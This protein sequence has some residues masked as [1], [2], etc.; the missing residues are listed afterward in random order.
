MYHFVSADM[1][2]YM[3]SEKMTERSVTQFRHR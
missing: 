3:V 1:F 2:L